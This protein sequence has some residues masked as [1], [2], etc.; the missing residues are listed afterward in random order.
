M[1]LGGG[2]A[3]RIL[4][5]FPPSDDERRA[6]R[7]V[8]GLQQE[9]PPVGRQRLTTRGRETCAGAMRDHATKRVTDQHSGDGVR[10]PVPLIRDAPQTHRHG[11]D[12]QSRLRDAKV[13]PEPQ[14]LIPLEKVK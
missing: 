5:R 7:R 13:E 1:R 9:L 11:E 6:A 4:E 3:Q 2:A 10:D 14:D 8:A 12:I